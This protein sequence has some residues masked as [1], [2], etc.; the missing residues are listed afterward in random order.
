MGVYGKLVAKIFSPRHQNRFVYSK[1]SL[2]VIVDICNINW[3]IVTPAISIVKTMQK[4]YNL[5]MPTPQGNSGQ[6]ERGSLGH[7]LR[8]TDLR[9]SFANPD[10][11]IDDSFDLSPTDTKRRIA[12]KPKP[13]FAKLRDKLTSEGLLLGHLTHFDNQHVEFEVPIEAR[14]LAYEPNLHGSDNIGFS[15]DDM[16][17][18]IGILLTKL[19]QAT[20]NK[21]VIGGPLGRSLAI[22][23]FTLPGE[24]F[25]FFSPAIE[26]ALVPLSHQTDPLGYY[27]VQL[28]DEFADRFEKAVPMFRSGYG[29]GG[30]DNGHAS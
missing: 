7:E 29:S 13:E 4:C 27:A 19:T 23:G 14:P 22:V 6:F 10:L 30:Q 2:M 26:R 5:S 20:D 9:F 8:P 18:Q 3:L 24:Q 16:F 15:D 25:M 21:S 11:G 17:Y 12:F 1:H 28:R